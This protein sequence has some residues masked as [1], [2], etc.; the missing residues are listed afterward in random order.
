MSSIQNSELLAERQVLERQLRT[1]PRGG[2]NQREEPQNR[3][4]HGR[5]VSGPG[6][7]KV[8]RFNA[9]GVLADNQRGQP[10]ETEQW[11]HGALYAIQRRYG[12][13]LINFP[14]TSWCTPGQALWQRAPFDPT[15]GVV[16]DKE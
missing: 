14:N 11:V 12:G 7:C 8:N 1:E 3:Q 15:C 16:A 6:A 9:A 4:G 10:G 5:E 2:R 13:N